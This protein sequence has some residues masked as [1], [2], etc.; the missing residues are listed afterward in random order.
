MKAHSTQFLIGIFL[1]LLGVFFLLSTTGVIRWEEEYSV[2]VVFFSVGI[3]LLLAYYLFQ[4]KIWTLILGGLGLF[5]GSAIYLD[6]SRIL[7]EASIGMILFLLIGLV[8]LNTLRQGKQK[9][10]AIIPGGFCLIISAHILLDMCW[11]LPDE[12]HG[13][14]FFGGSGLIFGIVYL[15]KDEKYELDW[16]KYPSIIAFIIAGLVMLAVDFEDIFSRVIF[17]LAL[18]VVGA[19]ILFKSVKKH[20]LI[21]AE[22]Q[23]EALDQ[24]EED[25]TDA[26]VKKAKS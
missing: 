21:E 8:F 9:W 4:K 13:V 15:L 10:W 14:L 22:K 11:W 12:Y 3:V 24:K 17:P 19:L 23:E 7:P 2:S 18:I 16:A 5:I 1:I 25:T 20:G 6:E 26:G